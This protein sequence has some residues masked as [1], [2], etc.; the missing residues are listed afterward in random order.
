MPTLEPCE[1]GLTIS[2][3]LMAASVS[4][5]SSGGSS[6][7]YSG[8]AQSRA[9]PDAL[10]LELVHGE[11]ARRAR[12][13]RCTGCPTVGE[14]P[15]SAPSSPPGP[16][17][18][19]QARWDA[20]SPGSCNRALARIEGVAFTARRFSRRQRRIAAQER[21]FPSVESP[22]KS[23][24]T[25]PKSCS[26]ARAARCDQALSRRHAGSPTMRTSVVSSIQLDRG[27]RALHVQDQ[28]L[29]VGGACSAMIDDEIRVLIGYR[30]IADAKSLQARAFDQVRRMIAR[31]VHEHRAAAPFADRLG[32]PAALQ[33]VANRGVVHSGL[34]FEFQAR[35]DEPFA[36]GPR[37]WR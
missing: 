21:D 31:R 19:I 32:L 24:A 5:K 30:C 28:R 15:A 10:G 13:C 37:T 11:R 20:A 1:A 2:G 8:A 6:S 25:R 36:A 27:D 18:A 17:S 16:C 7:A 14:R 33:Q 9:L 29:D 4:R 22:P 34:A 3:S 26:P 23:T 35:G 12:R